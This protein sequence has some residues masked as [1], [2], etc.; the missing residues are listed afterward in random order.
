[1]CLDA[2]YTS[3]TSR[4]LGRNPAYLDYAYQQIS[5]TEHDLPIHMHTRQKWAAH[6][7]SGQLM[8]R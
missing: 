2:A 5:C 8:S 1:M 7:P 3:E 4:N 6:W